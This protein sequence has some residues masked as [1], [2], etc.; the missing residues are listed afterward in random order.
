MKPISVML[1]ACLLLSM[2]TGCGGQNRQTSPPVPAPPR[3]SPELEAQ[4]RPPEPEA[5]QPE[6]DR[7]VVMDAPLYRGVITALSEENGVYELRLEQVEGADFGYPSFMMQTGEDTRADFSFADL[8]PGDYLEVFYGERN[9]GLPPII[10][11]A[12]QLLPAADCIF[13]GRLTALEHLEDQGRLEMTALS[14]EE[15]VHFHFDDSTQFYLDLDSLAPG[16]PLN[17]YHR[18]TMTRSIPPQGFALEVRPYTAP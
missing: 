3:L 5:A 17:I 1:L 12:N 8:V 13:N 15:I 2:A 9:D 4:E 16:D 7:L 10:I 14:G 18:G 6:E 11:A